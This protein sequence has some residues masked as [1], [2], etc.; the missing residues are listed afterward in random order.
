MYVDPTGENWIYNAWNWGE[1]NIWKGI[2][3]GVDIY[4]WHL[5]AELLRLSASGSGHTYIATSGDYAS[6]LAKNDYGINKFVNDTIWSYGSSKNN[7][8]PT[9]PTQSYEI[10]LS[11]GDLGAALHNVN[12]DI[13][14]KRNRDGSW[15]AIVTITDTFD[16]TQFKNPFR[17]GSVLKGFLWTA[18]DI[19]YYDT[20]WGLLDPVGVNITYGKIY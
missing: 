8:N 10:P 12:I 1:D 6:N 13:S 7:S 15:F 17:Q 14:A 11:N 20:E 2:A 19:A 16:F 3:K 5:S 4:G 9:I 18:N